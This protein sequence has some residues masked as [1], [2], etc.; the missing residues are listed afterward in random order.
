MDYGLLSEDAR[1]LEGIDKLVQ[2]AR[3]GTV[4]IMCGEENPARCHRASIIAP[5]LAA[6]GARVRHIRGSGN[7]DPLQMQ[8]QQ[9]A[10]NSEHRTIEQI[11]LFDT[12]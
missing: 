6:R 12:D 7:L 1:F 11:D 5:L 8:I 9:D 2:L 4:C 3:R 10:K